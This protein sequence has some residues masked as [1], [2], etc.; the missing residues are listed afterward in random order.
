[1]KSTIK[2][3]IF[4]HNTSVS[5]EMREK[6][7]GH[8]GL[9]IWFTGLSGSGKSTLAN[10]LEKRLH[11][12]KIRTYLL[13]GDNIRCGINNDLN[14]SIEDRKE[15]IRRTGEVAKLFV[16]A[17]LVVISCLISPFKKDRNTVRENFLPNKF[18]EVFIDCDLETCEKRDPKNLYKK[19]RALQ[20][21]NFT[22]ISSPYEKPEK[23]QLHIKNGED[24]DPDKNADMIFRYVLKIL[25]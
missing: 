12:I 23:P 18:I 1:M 17:G 2:G 9:C 16:D 7:N 19:A 14:F 4:F 3:N 22:G 25:K 15:N 11:E 8:K 10:M 5:A 20:I 24:S 21:N 6:M 13:D